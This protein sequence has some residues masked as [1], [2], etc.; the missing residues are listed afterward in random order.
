MG[1]HPV[2]LFRLY[3]EQFD[4]SQNLHLKV[5]NVILLFSVKWF[6]ASISKKYT[7]MKERINLPL[8]SIQFFFF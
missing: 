6:H 8:A 7:V 5:T 2:M 4:R 1:L 3:S